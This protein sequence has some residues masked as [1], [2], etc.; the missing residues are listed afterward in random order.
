MAFVDES[1]RHFSNPSIPVEWQG[2]GLC[3]PSG[4]V[5]ASGGTLM[6]PDGDSHDIEHDI[7]SVFP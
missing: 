2:S 1:D 7:Q 5:W 3:H 4:K 6:V